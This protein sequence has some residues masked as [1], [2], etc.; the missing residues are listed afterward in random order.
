MDPGAQKSVTCSEIQKRTLPDGRL[1][2][3]ANIRNLENRRLQ[4]QIDCVFKDEQGFEVDSTPWNTLILTENATET[5]RFE[6]ANNQAKLF[7]IRV[8]E[9]R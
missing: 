8:R 5:E 3:A 2:V 1:Q 4:V 6:S 9:A 7:T